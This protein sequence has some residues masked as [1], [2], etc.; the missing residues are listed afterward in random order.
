M[1]KPKTPPKQIGTGELLKK[2]RKPPAPPARIH[3][4]KKKY[5]R[6][7]VRISEDNET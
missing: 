4:G 2:I 1:P 6:S 7:R 3:A 5:K